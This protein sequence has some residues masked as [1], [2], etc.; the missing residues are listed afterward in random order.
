[1]KPESSSEQEKP[2]VV[3]FDVDGT[4]YDQSRLRKK[5]LFSLLS[6]YALR[7]WK[8]QEMLIL[9]HFRMEREKRAGQLFEDLE[10]DQYTWCAVKGKYPVEKVKK[11]VAKW[12]FSFPNQ[13][14]KDCLY[15]GTKE[16]FEA[17]RNNEITVAIYSDY[18]AHDKL[19]AMGLEADLVV[20][21]TD[22]EINCLKPMPDGLNYI[23]KKLKVSPKECLFIGDRQEM[24]GE[25]AIRA[26]MPYLIIEKKPYNK[27]NFFTKL[28]STL[29]SSP[30]SVTHESNN[31]TT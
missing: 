6:Y 23:T 28:K 2:A 7:P 1:M 16:L 15:P 20:S 4:L 17:L 10:N 27:F 18:K 31:Y 12:I 30:D 5:M 26:H 29:I 9:Q 25:C 3:I 11:V 24:D 8:I 19:K 21:S 22:P 13:Y 14:L